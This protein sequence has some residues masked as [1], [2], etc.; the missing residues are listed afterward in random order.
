MSNKILFQYI[1]WKDKT[2]QR[3][4][5][6]LQPVTI[7]KQ[8][9]TVFNTGTGTV[10]NY[11]KCHTEPTKSGSRKHSAL[12]HIF[13]I[14]FDQFTVRWVHYKLINK[15]L[16]ELLDINPSTNC[17]NEKTQNIV[18]ENKICNHQTL[19]QQLPT[20]LE[21][22]KQIDV[23]NSKSHRPYINSKINPKLVITDLFDKSF[24]A[25]NQFSESKICEEYLEIFNFDQL[26]L[27]CFV[28]LLFFSH[29]KF[30]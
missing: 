22:K 14:M 9:V 8:E 27:V 10:I 2:F 17:I 7:K 24:C 28:S 3:R 19:I 1:L 18:N 4:T 29:N 23:S 13:L 12:T 20:G 30:N 11:G 26:F 21:D 5:V 16:D 15:R 25:G 6:Y